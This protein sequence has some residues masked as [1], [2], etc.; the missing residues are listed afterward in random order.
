MQLTKIG[1]FDV[2]REQLSWPWI[3]FDATGRRFA[4]PSSA[5][6]IESRALDDAGQLGAGPTFSLPADLGL[7]TTA[8]KDE[9]V[10]DTRPGVHGFSLDAT[11]TRLAIT[12]VVDTTSFVVTLEP[13]GQERRSPLDAVAGPGFVAQAVAFDR[14]GARLW[15]SAESE[16][17]T[18]LVLVDAHTHALVGVAKSA[19][20]PPPATHEL[21]LHPEEDAVLL[22]AACGQDGTFARVVRVADG[23]VKGLWTSLEGGGIPAGMVGFSADATRVHLAEADEL[24]THAWPG[25]KELSS[26]QFEDDFVAS[27]SGAVLGERILVDGQDSE[28]KED[29]V[30]IFDRTATKGSLVVGPVPSGMWA[31]RL[32]TDTLV[33]VESKGEPSRGRVVRVEL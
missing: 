30:M 25:M 23:H 12:G 26:V 14:S 8:P 3:T 10:R 27:Y 2:V 29:A 20:F 21:Y 17:E 4:F 33:T 6:H 7:P 15:I 22:L 19:P 24:R 9:P 31:G 13:G 5:R 11:G 32:G 1:T 18:A 28:T 16:T